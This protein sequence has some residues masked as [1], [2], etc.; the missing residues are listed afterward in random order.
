VSH[1]DAVLVTWDKLSPGSSPTRNEANFYIH[2][3]DVN[4]G[5]DP[6]ELELWSQYADTNATLIE[7]NQEV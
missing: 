3:N 2:P 1:N 5:G 6:V 7:G 4:E